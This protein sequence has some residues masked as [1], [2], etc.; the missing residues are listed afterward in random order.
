MSKTIQIELP[1]GVSEDD[2]K[3]EFVAKKKPKPKLW[4]PNDAA[5]YYFID[6]DDKPV[7]T[8]FSQRR[9]VDNYNAYPTKPL[10]RKAADY[11]AP[12]RMLVRTALEIDPEFEPD[13]ADAEQDKFCLYRVNGE[14]RI[15]HSTYRADYRTPVVSTRKKAEQWLE[16]V[17]AQEEKK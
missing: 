12:Y 14:Y 17:N 10:A 8:C 13:W 16:L 15:S 5:E 6:S 7:V 1:E 2:V 3:I 4:V 11:L 9:R